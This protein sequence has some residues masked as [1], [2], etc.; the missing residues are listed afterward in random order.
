MGFGSYDESEQ[1]EQNGEDIDDNDAV[2]V[3]ENTHDGDVSFE[4]DAS[5]EELLDKLEDMKDEDTDD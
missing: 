5:Q 2:T 3:H 4:S 1:Q